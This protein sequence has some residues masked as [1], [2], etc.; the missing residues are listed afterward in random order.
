[1]HRVLALIVALAAASNPGSGQLAP[2]GQPSAQQPM[3]VAASMA[4][5]GR[6]ASGIVP[7]GP[8]LNVNG[9]FYG[10]PVNL[11][12]SDLIAKL[13]VLGSSAFVK[14]GAGGSHCG[15]KGNHL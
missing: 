13:R 5:A 6:F 7:V 8:G 4:A 14:G 1:M 11:S 3:P 15:V 10:E 12:P 9:L 2:A